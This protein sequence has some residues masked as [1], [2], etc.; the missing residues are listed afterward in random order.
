MQAYWSVPDAEHYNPAE[1]KS[2]KDFLY[3][4]AGGALFQVYGAQFRLLLRND[5]NQVRTIQEVIVF[6]RSH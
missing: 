4:N 2:G 5:S 1:S 3:S 6:C